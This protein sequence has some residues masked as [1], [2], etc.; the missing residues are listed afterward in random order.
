VDKLPV[1]DAKQIVYDILLPVP[2]FAAGSHH[3]KELNDVLLKRLEHSLGSAA[4]S[5][6]VIQLLDIISSLVVTRRVVEPYYFLRF[7]EK[8][9][10]N[11]IVRTASHAHPSAEIRHAGVAAVLKVIAVIEESNVTE[12]SKKAV[13]DFMLPQNVVAILTVSQRSS[14]YVGYH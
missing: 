11:L 6:D 8:H 4:L 13:Y 2:N 1:E 14:A 3:M 10:S 5:N 9:V 12:D 7:A